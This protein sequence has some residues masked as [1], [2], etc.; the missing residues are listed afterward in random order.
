VVTRVGESVI[1]V[2]KIASTF[3][4]IGLTASLLNAFVARHRDLWTVAVDGTDRPR[5]KSSDGWIAR[6]GVWPT[7]PGSHR[8][9]RDR[10]CDW[11]RPEGRV[12]RA[13]WH[14]T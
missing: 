11:R 3:A 7:K 5:V 1:F 12:D 8:Q 2:R 4:S 9:Y 6:L 10:H 14:I 13:S